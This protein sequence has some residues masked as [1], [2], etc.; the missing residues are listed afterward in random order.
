MP[1][2][3][4]AYAAAYVGGQLGGIALGTAIVRKVMPTQQSSRSYS[5]GLY[6]FDLQKELDRLG[7]PTDMFTK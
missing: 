1:I 6:P 2:P 3:A 5:T 4:I 7:Y